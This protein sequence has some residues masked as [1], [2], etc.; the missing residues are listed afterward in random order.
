MMENNDKVR[1]DI[2]EA[3]KLMSLKKDNRKQSFTSYGECFIF[4]TENQEGVNKVVNYKGKDVL[5]I[6]S[7]GDQYLGAVYYDANSVEIYDIN[8]LTEYIS[9][10][11]IAS[12]LA[13]NYQEFL[14]FSFPFIEGEANKDFWN[15]NIFARVI[16]CL[17]E[18]QAY[19]WKDILPFISCKMYSGL[20][21]PGDIHN[22]NYVA[23]NGMPFYANEKEYNILKEKLKKIGFPKFHQIDIASFDGNLDS[24]FDLVYLSNIIEDIVVNKVFENRKNKTGL[25]TEDEVEKIILKDIL[26]SIYPVLKEDGMYLIDYRPNTFRENA[27]DYMFSNPNFIVSQIEPKKANYG[28]Y[29]SKD[30]VLTYKPKDSG[31]VW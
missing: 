14:K 9:Y 28:A 22:K 11:R 26:S 3:I 6:A 30:L 7:S 8:Y 15:A 23:T 20:I 25:Y 17:P 19:L 21:Y 24:K 18:R 29:D 31:I 2:Y 5:T 10:L 12:I 1:K 13:L 16:K 27:T 4:G